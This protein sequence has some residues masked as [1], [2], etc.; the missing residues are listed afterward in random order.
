MWH[1]HSINSFRHQNWLYITVTKKSLSTIYLPKCVSHVCCDK[2]Q[3]VLQTTSAFQFVSHS[4]TKMQ[5]DHCGLNFTGIHLPANWATFCWLNPQ[6]HNTITRA[7][8]TKNLGFKIIFCKILLP[9]NWPVELAVCKKKSWLC[10]KQYLVYNN[11]EPSVFAV[12]PIKWTPPT[13]PSVC[14]T[15]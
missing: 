10:H 9:A 14:W 6:N 11:N 7:S 8:I 5:Y 4:N 1:C 13:N 15:C 3:W 12:P 2:F